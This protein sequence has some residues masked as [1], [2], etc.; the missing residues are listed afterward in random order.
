M[1]ATAAGSS[2]VDADVVPVVVVG[3]G[4]VG[5]ALA[6][7]LGLQGIACAVIE[8]RAEVSTVR[9]RAK[10]TSAR[11]MEL[12]RRWGL[13]DRLR[14]RA[15]IPVD[16]SGDV[17]FCTTAA[18]AEV[19]RF[20]GTLGLDLSGSDLVAEAGQQIGQPVVEQVLR[21]SLA[22]ADGVTV[23]LGSRA[24]R[25]DADE[26]GV[27]VLV[28]DAAGRS[29]ALRARYVVGAD[30]ARSIVREA[31]GAGYEGGNAGKPNLSIVFRS[32]RLG[33]LIH[34]RAVHR[35][36]LNPAAPGVVGPLD[37]GD[38]WWAIA[39]GRPE[40]DRDAD[41]AAL[42]RAMVGADIDVDVLGTD[43]W[44]ARSLLA[45]SYRS[46]R[47]L[48]VGDAAHQNPPWGGHGFNT[49]IGDAAN[50]GWK[51]AAVLQGWAP[52]ALLDTYETERRPV[53]AATIAI[54]GRNAR[55]LATELAS[56]ELMAGPDRFAAARPA[57]AATVQ[58]T[59]HIEFH[60]LGLVLGYG[61]GEGAGDQT[62][63][64]ADFH[65]VAAV[66]NRLPHHWIGPGDSLYDHLGAGM[67]A[68]GDDA[69]TASLVAAA[70]RRG[71]PIAAVPGGLVD[72]LERFGAAV[73]LVR[74]DQHIAWLGQALTPAEADE[75]LDGVLARGLLERTA[76][77]EALPTA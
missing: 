51:L 49:G 45:G 15:P 23:L 41:P 67:T 7:E 3:G 57:A 14:A 55:T 68:I 75:V 40:D 2:A 46:G 61:Y 8:P 65:P 56:D 27:D 52:P 21:E 35:W 4:P 60:C 64:G 58:R 29:S 37:L 70:V 47:L 74:P 54:A 63:D 19:T 18:G 66:G 12:F 1:T 71:I 76:R 13:A 50:L 72:A 42:V 16:W 32:A 6:T 9:P 43:P 53:A 30:G 34:D 20:T 59:K 38:V 25:I 26:D 22:E 5:L 44:Q 69:D 62:T 31:M 73:V 24:I 11:S 48:L 17:V 36:I 28:E 39:T 33:G 10:T 77:A